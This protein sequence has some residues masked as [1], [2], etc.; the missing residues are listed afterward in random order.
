[1][2]NVANKSSKAVSKGSAASTKKVA[3]TSFNKGDKVK[4]SV[5][6]GTYNKAGRGGI[7]V[8]VSINRRSDEYGVKYAVG[9]QQEDKKVSGG[10]IE[11]YQELPASRSRSS[12]SASSSSTTSKSSSTKTTE[13]NKQAATTHGGTKATKRKREEAPEQYRNMSIDQMQSYLKSEY[14]ITVQKTSSNERRR[15]PWVDLLNE[16]KAIEAANATAAADS[17]SDSDDDDSNSD[18]EQTKKQANPQ[19]R[20]KSKRKKVA[21]KSRGPPPPPPKGSATKSTKKS[22]KKNVKSYKRE[23][24][25]SVTLLV[26][27]LTQKF[28]RWPA[29]KVSQIPCFVDGDDEHFQDLAKLTD[30]STEED[31]RDLIEIA[32]D[33]DLFKPRPVD[34][35][36]QD[37]KLLALNSQAQ[38]LRMSLFV[39]NAD[40]PHSKDLID[41]SLN[42]PYLYNQAINKAI[43]DSTDG[44]NVIMSLVVCWKAHTVVKSSRFAF[45]GR[46]STP[47]KA[48]PATQHKVVVQFVLAAGSV[49]IN[50]DEDPEFVGNGTALLSI[51]HDI[52]D[53]YDDEIL[54]VD[55]NTSALCNDPQTTEGMGGGIIEEDLNEVWF[56][57]L[58]PALLK[59]AREKVE[60]S[61]PDSRFYSAEG[62]TATNRYKQLRPLSPHVTK[63]LMTLFDSSAHWKT[64]THKNW[65]VN[66][67]QN[68]NLK[69]HSLV[70]YLCIGTSDTEFSEDH[71][72]FPSAQQPQTTTPT[73]IT[74]LPSPFSGGG[75]AKRGME[76]A[77]SVNGS[78]K[79]ATSVQKEVI[80]RLIVLYKMEGLNHHAYNNMHMQ[81]IAIHLSRSSHSL[82]QFTD[83]DKI[84]YELFSR[85]VAAGCGGTPGKDKFPPV[86]PGGDPPPAPTSFGKQG[87]S[88]EQL[89][90]MMQ[91]STMR[92]LNQMRESETRLKQQQQQQQQ[93]PPPQQQQQQQQQP[94]QTLPVSYLNVLIFNNFFK[95]I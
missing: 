28:G 48:P 5:V 25:R 79:A 17:D 45:S 15:A 13:T 27:F 46:S 77:N 61:G 11:L 75:G 94:Q 6:T 87:N 10:R 91:L 4:V 50:E 26:T 33:N 64:T 24:K 9:S 37:G 57:D 68:I 51:K 67:F 88:G 14:N 23:G 85:S 81:T 22:K 76:N 90:K 70:V 36:N 34:N 18:N 1:M 73:K 7:G 92:L 83:S 52:T 38:Q 65:V 86:V 59:C 19:L 89:D 39:E 53:T 93:P 49:S 80:E 8:I 60:G 69:F 55:L 16:A 47:K 78:K 12:S 63:E 58:M 44:A 29:I 42:S 3:T 35:H 2:S 71:T 84:P 31:I 72:G 62:S 41:S 82:K 20:Q 32:F 66:N 30:A 40:D 95:K 56:A 43:G 54:N 21:A 74:S